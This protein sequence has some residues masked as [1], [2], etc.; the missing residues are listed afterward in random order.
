MI[1]EKP[2]N[3][4]EAHLTVLK[5][6]TGDALEMQKFPDG[7]KGSGEIVLSNGIGIGSNCNANDTRAAAALI[8]F[9][10]QNDEASKLFASD[11]GLVAVDRQQDQQFNDPATSPAVGRQIRLTQQDIAIARRSLRQPTQP[12]HRPGVAQLPKRYR[13]GRLSIE[14]AVDQFF[15]QAAKLAKQ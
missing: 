1:D 7:P 5:K 11:N 15:E 2:P 12:V 4:F 13:S 3:Q 9:W 14:A 10:E 6:A 8:N